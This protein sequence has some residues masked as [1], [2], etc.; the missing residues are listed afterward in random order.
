MPEANPKGLR[1]YRHDNGDILPFDFIRSARKTI[2]LYV[3]RNG[4]VQVRAPLRVP[5]AQI[6]LFLH[7]RWDWLI[8]QRSRFMEEP[9]PAQVSYTDGETFLHLGHPLMLR[10]HSAS[11]NLAKRTENEL[12]V[13]ITKDRQEQAEGLA[14]IIELWQR[15]EA[16]RVFPLRLAFCHEAMKSLRIPFPELKIRKMRSR[17]GSC[18]RKAVVTLNLELIRMPPDSIDY[19]IT[20]E[21]CHLVEFNHSSRFYQVQSQFMP[22]W[23]ERKQKLEEL[24]RANYGL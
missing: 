1:E 18:T 3:H 20:H 22:D 13:S 24:A 7:E 6:Y 23:K 8:L 2:G 16:R 19:V 17:W 11:H 10:V 14:G 9:A 5:L 12:H 4:S 15:R 21:L